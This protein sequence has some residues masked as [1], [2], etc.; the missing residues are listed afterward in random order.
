M[1]L[2]VL[3]IA[4]LLTLSFLSR[5]LV[6]QMYA[7]VLLL[8]RSRSIGITVVTLVLFPGTVVHE[9]SHLFT[10]EI[11][12]VRT[13]KLELAP[14]NIKGE[15]VHVG[16]VAIAQTDPIR[17]T[18]IGLSPLINGILILTA[19]SYFLPDWI[20]QATQQIQNSQFV[21]L[22]VLESILGVYL[23]FAISNS[24]FASK[25]DLKGVPAVIITL[26]LFIGAFY[27][28]GLRITLSG[29]LLTTATAIGRTLVT[30]L[31]IVLAVNAL[32]LLITSILVALTSRLTKRVI[33]Y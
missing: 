29:T 6:N 16:T 5:A 33:R 14:Q 32:L 11:L 8:T 23:V 26:L 19:L 20:S 17:R 9:L 12:G 13:G 21:S 3:F 27:L 1:L 4:E 28:V 24:M 10:A 18:F 31:G 22:P 30:S 15:E 25:E 2:F 7:T